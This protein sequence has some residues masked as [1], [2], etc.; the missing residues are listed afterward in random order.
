MIISLLMLKVFDLIKFILEVIANNFM[1]WMKLK[2]TIIK[3]W[4]LAISLTL[5]LALTSI[6]LLVS[7]KQNQGNF[8]Y[9]LDDAYIH[10]AMAKNYFQYGVWGIT[11]HE[12]TS[13][14]SSLLWMLLISTFYRIF[15]VNAFIPFIINVIFAATTVSLVY[16]IFTKFN[17]SKYY[18]LLILTAIIFL[19]PFTAIIFSGMEHMLQIFLLILFIYVSVEVLCNKSYYFKYLLLIMLL[20]SSV[21]FESLFLIIPVIFLFILKKKYLYSILILFIS[22]IPYL[23]YGIISMANG[24]F[25]LPNSLVLKS[26]LTTVKPFILNNVILNIFN[27]FTFQVVNMEITLG[28][29]ILTLL[30][31]LLLIIS[32]KHDELRKTSIFLYIF[33]FATLLHLFFAN[34]GIFNRYVSYLVFLGIFVNSLASYQLIFGGRV[35]DFDKNKVF[36]YL[37]I[38]LLLGLIFIPLS[39][40]GCYAVM[41]TPTATKNIYE[42]QYQMA[43]FVKEYYNNDTIALNDIGA[44]N[45]LADIKCVDFY[46]LAN[47]QVANAKKNGSY[48]KNSILKITRQN[49]VK[50]IIIYDW[51]FKNKIP[52]EWI[53]VCD[54]KIHDNV[55][56]GGDTISFYVLSNEEKDKLVRNINTFYSKMPK[57]IDVTIYN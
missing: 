6:L 49:D 30:S 44:V 34:I 35:L 22:L 13:T 43:L 25:F 26:F 20:F 45:Y 24:W 55:V 39:G 50:L 4:P 5:L 57:S 40:G 1:N 14:S 15:G 12:F 53:K 56:C 32:L 36:G 41:E 19:T 42:Q 27:H 48:D 51:W 46:G 21:R 7:L 17:I 52:K 16:Y 54:W 18:I 3:N 11:K 47:M 29:L 8:V 23:I 9:S 10:M 33:I 2:E 37:T 31:L 28:L 38:I